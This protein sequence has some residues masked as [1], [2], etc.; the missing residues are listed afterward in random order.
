MERGGG[1]CKCRISGV[2]EKK[3]LKEKFRKKNQSVFGWKLK[4][5]LRFAEKGKVKITVGNKVIAGEGLE[6]NHVWASCCKTWL[7]FEGKFAIVKREKKIKS[8][9]FIYWVRTHWLGAM[10]RM[11]Q[12]LGAML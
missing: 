6:P 3:K 1:R 4:L 10:L 2:R 7:K 11:N 5:K 9:I 12:K 8:G